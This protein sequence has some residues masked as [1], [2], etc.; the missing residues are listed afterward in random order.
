MW[1]EAQLLEDV[2]AKLASI[3]ELFLHHSL[4]EE[5]V[6]F[7]H[8]A[9]FAVK[10]PQATV[11]ELGGR[12]HQ[13]GNDLAEVADDIRGRNYPGRVVAISKLHNTEF[14]PTAPRARSVAH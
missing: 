12:G 1:D 2:A 4:V 14:Q 13:F 6:P 7:A 10:L 11:R 9:L 8:L 5:V 3:A